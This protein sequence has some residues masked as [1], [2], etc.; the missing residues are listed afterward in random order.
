[1]ICYKCKQEK[2]LSDFYKC[3]RNPSGL[4]SYCKACTKKMNA[5]RYLDRRSRPGAYEGAKET[6]A[7]LQGL[8]GLLAS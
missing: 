2:E 3:T 8:V 6:L 7:E 1:M 5:E 4:L